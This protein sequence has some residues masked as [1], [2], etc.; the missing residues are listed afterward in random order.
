MLAYGSY[1]DPLKSLKGKFTENEI[2]DFV[3]RS[4]KEYHTKQLLSI[5]FADISQKERG[6]YVKPE[7]VAVEEI[8]FTITDEDDIYG[9]YE[10][11]DSEKEPV[12]EEV[13][14]PIDIDMT[15]GTAIIEKLIEVFGTA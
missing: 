14:L 8:D 7:Q 3:S 4:S 5:M 13:P 9:D 10:F 11:D 2:I 1:K 15:D 6:N 12:K